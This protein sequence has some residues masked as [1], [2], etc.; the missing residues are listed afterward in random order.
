V[1]TVEL[2]QI[3]TGVTAIAPPGQ[4]P[5]VTATAK[6]Q[7]V[8]PI[9]FTSPGAYEIVANVDK[10]LTSSPNFA[11]G[12]R[13]PATD[14]TCEGQAY[15]YVMNVKFPGNTLKSIYGTLVLR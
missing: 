6:A 1:I 13:V 10:I 12:T 15:C 14:T 3:V 4:L 2:N 5:Q 9:T 8:A 11:P 7:I